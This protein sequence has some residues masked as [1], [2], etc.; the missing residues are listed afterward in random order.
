VIALEKTSF[1]KSTDRV[2]VS[3]HI[4]QSFLR[5][6]EHVIRQLVNLHFHD[7]SVSIDAFDSSKPVL[8]QLVETQP[9]RETTFEISARI[10]SED[11]DFL[12]LSFHPL[13]DSMSRNAVFL[14]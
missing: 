1:G 7:T 4:E 12:H 13:C 3:E 14:C 10:E 8:F 11:V 6:R 9:T 2:D 5:C